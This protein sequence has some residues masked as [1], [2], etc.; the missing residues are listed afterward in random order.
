MKNYIYENHIISEPLL[1]FIFHRQYQVSMRTNT[2]NWHTN[3]EILYCIGGSGFVRCGAAATE[4]LPGDIFVVNPDTP[5]SIGSNSSVKYRCLIIDNS[6]CAENG[7]P[8]GELVFESAIRD[9]ELC[10]LFDD[11]TDAYD[12]REEKD[13]CAVADIRYAVL[14]LLRILCRKSG[15]QSFPRVAPRLLPGLGKPRLRSIS[16]ADRKNERYP[17]LGNLR[18]CRSGTLYHQPQLCGSFP[19]ERRKY[20]LEVFSQSSPR[21]SA[22]FSETCQSH[23]Q[24]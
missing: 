19:Q 7:I 21:C 9:P 20:H 13:Y 17:R 15:K 23:W 11:V 24:R 8:I 18:R 22:G 1:P 6:F 5:H 12:Q 4:F 2:P 16:R 3:M 14:G 10:A